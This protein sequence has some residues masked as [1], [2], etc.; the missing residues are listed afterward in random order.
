[1]TD[2]PRKKRF[3]LLPEQPQYSLP[4]V[5]SDGNQCA[6]IALIGHSAA[7]KSSCLRYMKSEAN[8]DM[9]VALGTTKSP[10]LETAI[11]WMIDESRPPVIAVSNHEVMLEALHAAK[12]CGSHTTQ[13]SR[14]HFVY[15]HKPKD[16]LARHLSRT[17]PGGSHRPQ[18]AQHYT[19]SE[20]ERFHKMFMDLA[21]V[22]IDCSSILVPEVAALVLKIRQQIVELPD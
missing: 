13:L 21:D 2:D 12:V 6:V 14:I 8:A 22:V 9:D 18:P 11:G 19:L 4:E 5:V 15:L 10:S 3:V 16:R 17:T 1:M 7:G 20:Y